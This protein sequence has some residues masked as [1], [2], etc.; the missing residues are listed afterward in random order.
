MS[1]FIWN[2]ENLAIQC[3]S[4]ISDLDWQFL[5][6]N[7]IK[8]NTL[9]IDLNQDIGLNQYWFYLHNICF[10]CNDTEVWYDEL[11]DIENTPI[12][13]EILQDKN[14]ILSYIQNNGISENL[15]YEVLNAFDTIESTDIIKTSIDNNYSFQYLLL[16]LLDYNPTIKY[17]VY[18]MLIEE[19]NKNEIQRA[20]ILIEI[21]KI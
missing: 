14:K 9:N 15:S 4:L 11:Q 13:I 8:N 7:D 16:L 2:S 1:V 19:F 6:K 20:E 18:N 12:N 17:Q 21:Q 10:Y 5:V 3:L